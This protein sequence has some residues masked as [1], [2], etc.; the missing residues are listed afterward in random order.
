MQSAMNVRYE[1]SAR[2]ASPGAVSKANSESDG[3]RLQSL[4][5]V[6]EIDVVSGTDEET[7][8]RRVDRRPP[9][10]VPQA[11]ARR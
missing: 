8:E 2:R 1:A 6:F 3:G 5:R 11:A 4:Q 10:G 7:A 9:G